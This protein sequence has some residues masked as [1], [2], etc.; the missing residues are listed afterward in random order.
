VRLGLQPVIDAGELHDAVVEGL[1]RHAALGHVDA[2][3][4]GGTAAT[5]RAKGPVGREPGSSGR[6]ARA[7]GGAVTGPS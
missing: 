4:G 3:P 6:D 2:S 7:R 5:A 1:E